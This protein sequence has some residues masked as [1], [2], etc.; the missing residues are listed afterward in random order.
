[1]KQT[2]NTCI[3]FAH[4]AGRT[5]NPPRGLAT[6][7]ACRYATRQPNDGRCV[8]RFHFGAVSS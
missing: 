8:P 7:H 6:A 3:E 2:H 5:A 1:M 4:Y